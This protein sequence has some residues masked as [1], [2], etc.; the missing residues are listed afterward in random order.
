MANPDTQPIR[1]N[2]EE[3]H[4]F[5]E[6]LASKPRKPNK[7]QLDAL[8]DYRRLIEQEPTLLTKKGPMTK[9]EHSHWQSADQRAS[10]IAQARAQWVL[11]FVERGVFIDPSEAVEKLSSH[12]A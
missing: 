7:H 12:T 5:A 3:S 10:D 6:A 11:D 1:L 2:A 8:R 9:D 4:R